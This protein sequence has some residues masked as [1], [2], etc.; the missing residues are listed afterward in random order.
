MDT[1]MT[2]SGPHLLRLSDGETGERSQWILPTLDWLRANPDVELPMAPR[3]S[4][5][6]LDAPRPV[7]CDA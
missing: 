6:A 7:D 1:A 5:V 3:E 4:V 2:R